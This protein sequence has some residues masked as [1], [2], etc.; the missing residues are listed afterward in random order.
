MAAYVRFGSKADI[1][2]CNHHVRFTPDSGHGSAA[3]ECPLCANRRHHARKEKNRLPAVSQ[4]LDQAILSS[5]DSGDVLMASLAYRPNSINNK[6]QSKW[7]WLTASNRRNDVMWCC[8]A[9]RPV[10]LYTAHDYAVIALKHFLCFCSNK[11][12]QQG[13]QGGGHANGSVLP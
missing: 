10:A 13:N 9:I 3:I 4:K 12:L 1:S 2:H 5:C 8:I 11:K 6:R 7:E